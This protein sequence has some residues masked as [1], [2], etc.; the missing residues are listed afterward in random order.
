[1]AELAGVP[2][3]TYE[4]CNEPYFGGVTLEWQQRIAAV[5]TQAE[6][7]LPHRHLIAQNIANGSAEVADPNPSVSILNF[8]YASPPDAVRVNHHLNR[9]IGFDET[10]FQ[11]SEDLPYRTQAWDFIL[12]GGGVYD[13][14]DYSFTAAHPDG[15]AEISAPGGGG[16]VLRSQLAILKRFIEGFDFIR[17]TPSDSVAVGGV[18]EGATARVL[19]EAGKQYAVYLKGGGRTE[20]VLDLP[21]GRYRAQWLDPR[22]GQTEKPEEINHH[23]GRLALSS[24]AYTEDIALG[25]KA[26]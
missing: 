3:L 1:V 9:V 21:A 14:L 22:T 12:A 5:I 17:M 7:A 24:P 20:L 25:I 26:R 8:H 10:G 13:N 19:A 15:T 11:G 16:A 6:S 2:N 4:I 18:L 23:G